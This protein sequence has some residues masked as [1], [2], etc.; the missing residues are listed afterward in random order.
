MHFKAFCA[1]LGVMLLCQMGF[2]A[3]A[4]KPVLLVYEPQEALMKQWNKSGQFVFQGGSY[5]WRVPLMEHLR[6]SNPP[7]LITLNTHHAPY[8]SLINEGLLADL[9]QDA[10]VQEAFGQLRPTFQALFRSPD[11]KIYGMPLLVSMSECTYWLPAHWEKAG[12]PT[13]AAPNSFLA[14]LDFLED[15]LRQP[16]AGFRV[17]PASD[18]TDG[19]THAYWLM[20]LLIRGWNAQA[21]YQDHAVQ[22][23]DPAFD[24]LIARAMKIGQ[25]LDQTIWE[26]GAKPLFS[27]RYCRGVT[28]NGQSVTLRNLI[29]ARMDG[30]QEKLMLFGATLIS[31]RAG[32]SREKQVLPYAAQIEAAQPGWARAMLYADVSPDAWNAEN[33]QY[34]ITDAWLDSLETCGYTP[35]LPKRLLSGGDLNALYRD[36]LDGLLS[37]ADFSRALDILYQRLPTERDL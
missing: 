9:S 25:T 33:A 30:T 24:M 7:D 1:A 11:G 32:S 2:S 19:M 29:P 31:V 20:N 4:E 5:D 12:L 26:D 16:Q 28:L 8:Q 34:P 35:F 23:H 10:Q 13:E 37:P 6:G 21:Q 15:W 27:C 18:L 22:F 17:L 14:L 3:Q 36:V